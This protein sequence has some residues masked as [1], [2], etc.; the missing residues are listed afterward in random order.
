D[1]AT[2][3]SSIKHGFSQGLP[4]AAGLR[5]SQEARREKG[6]W[7]RRYW[8]HQIR[9]EEDFARHVDYIHYNPVKHGHVRRVRDWPF[10]SFHRWV[11]RG[12]LPKEWGLVE[13]GASDKFGEQDPAS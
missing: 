7:Q 5:P 10:S 13:V 12:D 8:E 3:W 1:F 4:C 6:I 9:D 2:R 11:Q